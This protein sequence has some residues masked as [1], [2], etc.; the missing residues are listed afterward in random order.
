MFDKQVT[1]TRSHSYSLSFFGLLFLK[2][3]HYFYLKQDHDKPET[4]CDQNVTRISSHRY[5]AKNP[6][7][8]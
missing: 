3:I 7:F 1:A 8:P 5:A 2:T 6:L 4:I